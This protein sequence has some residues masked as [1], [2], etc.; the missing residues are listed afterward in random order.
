MTYKFSDY[1]NGVYIIEHY[2][3]KVVYDKPIYVGTTVLDISKLIMMKFYYDVI[4]KHFPNKHK[5]ALW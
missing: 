4:Q 3:P 5:K 2:K 1:F